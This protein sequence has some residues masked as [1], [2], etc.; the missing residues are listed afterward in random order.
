[1]GTRRSWPAPGTISSRAFGSLVCHAV[2]C[3]EPVCGSFEP[4]SRSVFAA[5]DVYVDLFDALL[6]VGR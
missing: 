5:N 2:P 4:K 3:F 6:G 1:V